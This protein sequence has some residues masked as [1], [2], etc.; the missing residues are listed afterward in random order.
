[1]I[2]FAF[3]MAFDTGGI[4]AYGL[5]KTI[6]VLLRAQFLAPRWS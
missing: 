2:S 1:M 4:L 3:F 5:G 6:S